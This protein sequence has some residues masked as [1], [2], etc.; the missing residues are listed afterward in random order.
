M[1]VIQ[2]TSITDKAQL[3]RVSGSFHN[4]FSFVVSV[5]TDIVCP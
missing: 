4:V 3:V 2:T 5:G 1:L